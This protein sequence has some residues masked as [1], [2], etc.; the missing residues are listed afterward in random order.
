MEDNGG[1]TFMH[2]KS[3]LLFAFLAGFSFALLTPFPAAAQFGKL[4]ELNKDYQK[5]SDG[6]YTGYSGNAAPTPPPKPENA[7]PVAGT[8]E[9]PIPA[10]VPVVPTPAV[11]ATPAPQPVAPATAPATGT[12]TQKIDP[13][14]AYMYSYDVYTVCQDRMQK[15]QRMQDAKQKRT[16]PKTPARAAP[17]APTP[18]PAPGGAPAADTAP[19]PAA[20]G[21]TQTPATAGPA[22][23]DGA[24]A[25][26]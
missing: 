20:D 17:A 18:A 15:I 5:P 9:M 25:K 12:D 10:P 3:V 13:C 7:P 2:A 8:P 14:A 21:K 19:A 16:K 6:G 22:A 4:N 24:A 1:S 23:S 11:P 26:P